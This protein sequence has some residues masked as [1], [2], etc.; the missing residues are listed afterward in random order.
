MLFADFVRGATL[1]NGTTSVNLA[2]ADGVK[3]RLRLEGVVVTSLHP[4][5]VAAAVAREDKD[6]TFRAS[7]YYSNGK[8]TGLGTG[9]DMPC[10]QAAA[11]IRQYYGLDSQESGQDS[12]SKS[13]R[14]GRKGRRQVEVES[15]GQVE[16]EAESVGAT[17]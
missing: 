6:V 13:G 14:K 4:E 2:F 7:G 10:D 12:E 1:R 11:R 8:R 15:N 5:A 16:A 17:V 3:A 9:A